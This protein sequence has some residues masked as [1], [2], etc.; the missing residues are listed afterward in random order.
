W[1]NLA[2][3]VLHVSR[4]ANQHHPFRYPLVLPVSS[5]FS[6][7]IIRVAPHGVRHKVV[8][9]VALLP[10]REGDSQRKAS[11]RRARRIGAVAP[12]LPP[13]DDVEPCHLA[14][15]DLQ[16]PKQVRLIAAATVL[17]FQ[18]DAA[19]ETVGIQFQL[20]LLDIAL[21]PAGGRAARVIDQM[22]ADDSLLQT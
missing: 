9:R 2:S 4:P 12:K 20:R 11:F 13:D 1:E 17:G 14:V 15:L 7:Q 3:N 16:E 19:L 22:I 6:S 5:K 21:T 18:M 8:Q 10:Q